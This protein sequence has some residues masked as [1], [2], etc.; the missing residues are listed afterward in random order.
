MKLF[1]LLALM[2]I[3]LF[4]CSQN[5]TSGDDQLDVLDPNNRQESV[6]EERSAQLGYVRYTKEEASVNDSDKEISIDRGLVADM[7]T[8]TLLQTGS[9]GEVA[10]LVTDKE[11]VITYEIDPEM[12]EAEAQ[13]IAE[14]TARSILPSFYE[15]YTSSNPYHMDEIHSLHLEQTNTGG[16]NE[17]IERIINRLEEDNHE[18]NRR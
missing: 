2:T 10:S 13:D 8:R 9:Y 15:I 11:V 1:T 18:P 16:D 7:I 4:G 12:T 3:F 6:N 17:V 14:K 5:E